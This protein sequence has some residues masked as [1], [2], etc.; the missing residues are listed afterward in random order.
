MKFLRIKILKKIFFKKGEYEKTVNFAL[1]FFEADI[2]NSKF[3]DCEF[4]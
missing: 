3:I 2:S 1:R 4:F